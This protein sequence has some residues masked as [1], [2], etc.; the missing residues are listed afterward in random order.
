MYE[1]NH[2]IDN[3]DNEWTPDAVERLFIFCQFDRAMPY[4]KVVASYEYLE[5]KN[6]LSFRALRN[7][8]SAGHVPLDE[9]LVSLL[10]DAKLRFPVQTAKFLNYNINV[11]SGR[12]LLGFGYKLASMFCNR[13]HG[14]QYAIIDVHIDRF[15]KE[16]GCTA[17]SYHEKE[18]FFIKLAR[19]RGV[20]P[21]QL[22]WEVWN[23]SRIGNKKEEEKHEN[24]C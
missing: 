9:N 12:T 2:Q 21:D 4:E 16:N 11:F 13:V 8:L 3:P 1:G 15:L 6:M 22:D 23:S 10:R 24:M 20:T 7:L 17:R 14:S 5:S 19:Q 18:K